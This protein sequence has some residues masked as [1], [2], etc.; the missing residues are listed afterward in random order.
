MEVIQQRGDARRRLEERADSEGADSG[1]PTDSNSPYM[2]ESMTTVLACSV[3][4]GGI[5]SSVDV[6]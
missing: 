5:D 6:G 1:S 3:L 2:D 4:F